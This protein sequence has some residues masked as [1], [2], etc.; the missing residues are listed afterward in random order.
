MSA[1]VESTLSGIMDLTVAAVPTGINAGV[2]IA[3]R[4]VLIVPVRALPEV[5][6]REKENSCVIVLCLGGNR[7]DCQERSR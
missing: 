6:A 7:A 4:G 2:R 5:A 1:P 3:P